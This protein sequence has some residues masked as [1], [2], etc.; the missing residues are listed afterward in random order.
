MKKSIVLILI[1][2]V[3]ASLFAG[4]SAKSISVSGRT[5]AFESLKT[6]G[7]EKTMQIICA[8]MQISFYSDG[9]AH[10]I[11]PLEYFEYKEYS[12][13]EQK[14]NKVEISDNSEMKGEKLLLTVSEDCVICNLSYEDITAE[15]TFAL[16]SSHSVYGKTFECTGVTFEGNAD[17]KAPKAYL[18]AG[19]KT[20]EE[21][22]NYLQSTIKNGQIT[23]YKN[24]TSYAYFENDVIYTVFPEDGYWMQEGEYV[25]LANVQKAPADNS[26][27]LFVSEDKLSFKYNYAGFEIEYNFKET[28]AESVGGKT[29]LYSGLLLTGD[30]TDPDVKE[31]LGLMDFS[32]I[33]E[34]K[35][36]LEE[37]IDTVRQIKFN[38]AETCTLSLSPSMKEAYNSDAYF[39]QNGKI[40]FTS[41]T[42]G[43]WK[44]EASMKFHITEDGD[45]LSGEESN[46]IGIYA[47]FK[48]AKQ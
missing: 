34:Y 5:Y 11:M 28:V 3:L 14:G 46:K 41:N 30:E 23:F 10:L 24:G 48:E 2:S 44:G 21:Y 4:C 47:V 16:K 37:K 32:T 26:C 7:D 31:Y 6:D 19:V 36:Y 17:E 33:E 20:E 35:L 43:D 12:Y 42:Y 25:F 39:I 15:V 1:I 18:E 45:L 13:W 29:Y 38:K 9:S 40:V 27:A 22:K 8:E